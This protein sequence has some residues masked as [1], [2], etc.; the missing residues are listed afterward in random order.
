MTT[1]NV[2]ERSATAGS[3]RRPRVGPASQARASPHAPRDYFRRG[4]L[5][6]DNAS[7]ISRRMASGRVGLGFGW[8]AIQESSAASWSG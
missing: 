4:G 6:A 3:P 7:S 5:R 2:Q 1:H 8:A